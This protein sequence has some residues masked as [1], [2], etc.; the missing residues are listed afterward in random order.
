MSFF[1]RS[2]IEVGCTYFQT[3]IAKMTLKINQDHWR[4]H[5]SVGHISFS[6]NGLY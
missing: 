2:E 6:I 4:W 5:N 3:K 1:F